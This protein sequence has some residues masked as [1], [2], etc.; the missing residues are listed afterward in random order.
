[1]ERSE[2]P[3][4]QETNVGAKLLRFWEAWKNYEVEPWVVKVLQEGYKIPFKSLPPLSTT[5]VAMTA[6][7]QG[8][9]RFLALQEEVDSLLS[10]SA[11]DQLEI[12]GPGYYS[13]LFVATK[14]SGGW[15]P[16]LDVS[17]LN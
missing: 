9:E 16:V 1:M 5:P 11:V 13:R 8:S 3:R 4:L 15:R 14:A 10:K 2:V 7:A 17:P 6:Y 12:P